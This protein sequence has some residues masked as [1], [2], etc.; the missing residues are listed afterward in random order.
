MRAPVA[1]PGRAHW[2]E[3]VGEDPEERLESADVF[4]Q[5]VVLRLRRDG[6][7]LLRIVGR[8]GSE[9][10]IDVHPGQ[11]AG[12]IG[13]HHNE[14]YDATVHHGSGRVLHDALRPGTTSTSAQGERTLRKKTEV[15]NYD[16][17]EYVSER[18]AVEAADGALIPVTVARRRDTPLDGT[19]PCLLYAY[20]SYES[21]DWPEL[22]PALA[23]SPEPWGRVRPRAHPRRRRTREAL[24]GG[25]APEHQAEHVRRPHRR[26]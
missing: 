16:A 18:Y 26:R 15:P 17:G 14:D 6:H 19:A 24:V 11:E 1:T 23:S 21:T 12:Y 9:S 13:L 20:G 4:A 7:P 22:D 2:E 25:R 5:H 8:D 10:A 3:L